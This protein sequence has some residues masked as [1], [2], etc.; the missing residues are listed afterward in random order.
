MRM[1][2]FVIYDNQKTRRAPARIG[3]TTNAGW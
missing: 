2:L 1:R 3:Q